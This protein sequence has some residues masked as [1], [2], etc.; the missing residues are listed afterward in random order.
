MTGAAGTLLRA[1]LLAGSGDFAVI[2]RFRAALAKIRLVGDDRLLQRRDAL[3]FFKL[4][5]RKFFFRAGTA[6]DCVNFE[7]H[8]S[9]LLI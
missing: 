7:F 4:R 3:A 5:E 1:L 8:R 2:L 6:V 9:V